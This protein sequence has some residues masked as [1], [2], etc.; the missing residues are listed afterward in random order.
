MCIVQNDL[1][2]TLHVIQHDWN[3]IESFWVGFA[4]FNIKIKWCIDQW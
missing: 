3:G 2:N 1:Y 4:A